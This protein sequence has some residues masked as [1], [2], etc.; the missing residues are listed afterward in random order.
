LEPWYAAAAENLGALAGRY[1]AEVIQV[2][3]ERSA[4]RA[5]WKRKAE[6]ARVQG[7]EP[8]EAPKFQPGD[9]RFFTEVT[10]GK[11]PFAL[12]EKEK[13]QVF[14][15]TGRA[16]DGVLKAELK[17]LKD[18]APPEPPMACGVAEGKMVE[19]AVFV[20]GN[21]GARGEIVAKRFPTVLAGEEQP[22]IA[23]G[24]GRRELAEW[25]ASPRNPLTPRVMANR[26]WQWHFGEGLV[27]TASNFGITGERPSHA[28]LLDWLAAEFIARGWSVKAMHRLCMLSSAYRMSSETTPA[29]LEQDP[30]NRL[31][32]YFRMRRLTVEEIRD[33]LLALDGSL[34]LTMGGSL[35]KGEGT[36]KEF[37]DDRKSLNPD[38]SKR[39]T[40]YLP[41]R[42]SNLASLFTMF[43][44]GD[45]TTSNES[46]AQTN[47][48]PQ[49]LYMMNSEFVAD[50]ARS[51]A[52]K[53]LSGENT[54]ERR[55]ERAWFLV[56]GRRPALSEG[57]MALAY[58]RNFP[59]KSGGEDADLA[60]WSS[61]CRSLVASNDFIY[62]H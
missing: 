58:L 60:A 17:Q 13:E 14:S 29:K 23:A 50:R 3:A 37:S 25:L 26:I 2:A 43:D 21:P 46:R 35:Q 7:E 38:N 55:I 24:S 10:S 6:A 62:V 61:L 52:Q 8:P 32:S 15:E 39:R 33:S 4:A 11:G 34:D 42:R 19:Q 49:A 48:A 22:P 27:R 57:A 1:Q 51:L 40:V 12:P 44:F 53:L 16:R 5:E 9:D 20:R 31:L 59:G 41:L 56:L 45:A 30:D 47:V 54:D 36:D 18:S 28:E